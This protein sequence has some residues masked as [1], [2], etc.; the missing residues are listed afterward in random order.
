M[1][2]LT[3]FRRIL[4]SR[5]IRGAGYGAL[6]TV[7][8]LHLDRLGLS[9]AWIG[10][11]LT[12]AVAGSLAANLLWT[13]LADRVGRRRTVVI[14]SFVM[15]ASGF[16]FALS[17]APWLLL[18]TA[19]LGAIS[20]TA[21]EVGPFQTV[22]QVMIPQTVAAGRRTRAFAQYAMAGSLAAACGSL[23]AGLIAAE[24][25]TAV[26]VLYGAIG[27]ANAW[28]FSG[29]SDAV[30]RA[31]VE[32]A[33]R[34]AGLGPSRGHVLR[35]AA[36]FMVDSFAGGLV[37]QAVAAWWFHLRWGLDVVALGALFFGFHVLAGL[38]MLLAEPL[39]RR[40]G[41]LN[42]MVFTHV[43]ANVLLMLVPFAPSVEAA[44]ALFLLRMLVSQMDVPARQA[45]MMA[46]VTPPER[47]AA[48]GLTNIA[49]G[50]ASAAA[51]ALATWAM[52]A[53][54]MSAG[55]T[56]A[57]ATSAAPSTGDLAL[58]LPFLAAGALKLA[59]DGAVW[60]S[61]RKVPLPADS[62]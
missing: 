56:S 43:P 51:P 42:T 1:P 2:P 6:A 38:S 10:A 49:R 11:I 59:Y 16:V 39:S 21:S 24:S 18:I 4:I 5:G 46:L 55:A 52:S 41:L 33:A 3:D 7:L 28:L 17:A 20:T 62:A 57:G 14:M 54:A 40:I 13:L 9:T 50:L 15:A 34:F 35:M 25:K 58:S 45:Y 48:A 47:L 22:E 12:A 53:G 30:E 31:K 61:F 37:V 27:L 29:L 26:F 8:V 44:V 36:L 60:W 19:F 32:G 23:G